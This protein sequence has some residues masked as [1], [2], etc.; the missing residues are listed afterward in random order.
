MPCE[1][2]RKYERLKALTIKTLIHTGK[3]IGGKFFL[4]IYEKRQA[5]REDNN[6]SCNKIAIIIS[7]K[8]V[9]H[10][11]RRNVIR[12]LVR[13]A[14]RRNKDLFP[15]PYNILFVYR[16]TPEPAKYER[17]CE[18]LKYLSQ[19]MQEHYEN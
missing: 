5:A 2:F 19:E 11:S 15:S 4:L 7:K 6:N 12:R 10:A 13:E 9:K 3:K 1:R 14:Y 8:G 16:P 17:I 18:D